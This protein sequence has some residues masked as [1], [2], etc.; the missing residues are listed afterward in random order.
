MMS[1]FLGVFITVT[2]CCEF[3]AVP[4][5]ARFVGFIGH[6]YTLLLVRCD[7]MTN[8]KPPCVYEGLPLSFLV[9]TTT[10]R[11]GLQA[12]MNSHLLSITL[13]NYQNFN[14]SQCVIMQAVCLRVAD[15]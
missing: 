2:V 8:K 11:F 5:S 12:L 7:N 10:A 6:F 15:M 3:S 9:Y 14:F 4:V 13:I 1:V